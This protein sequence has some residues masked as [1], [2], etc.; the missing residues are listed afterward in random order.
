MSNLRPPPGDTWP[1][2]WWICKCSVASS[3]W[4]GPHGCAFLLPRTGDLRL[5]GLRA[6]QRR[7]TDWWRVAGT[8]ASRVPLL[9]PA[10]GGREG[11]WPC[12]HLDSGLQK[13]ETKFPSPQTLGLRHSG[14]S[15]HRALIQNPA[16]H[17][18]E[19]AQWGLVGQACCLVQCAELRLQHWHCLWAQ[20]QVLDAPFPILL[21]QVAWESSGE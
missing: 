14:H 3:A 18:A 16:R 2:S 20:V 17:T 7:G 12:T 11:T 4:E 6:G 10:E 5:G 21:L 8:A 1:A 13:G 15:S 19:R 9:W